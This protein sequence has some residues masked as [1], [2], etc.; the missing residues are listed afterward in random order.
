[1]NFVAVLAALIWDRL[2]PTARALREPPWL[3]AYVRAV[4]RTVG[5]ARDGRLARAAG[6]ALLP[7]LAVL[8]VCALVRGE[9]HGTVYL[10][11][12]TVVLVFALGP[13]D[14]RREVHGYCAAA[15]K[16]DAAAASQLGA[17]L[18]GHDAGQ[19]RGPCLESVAE[20][21]F[22]QANNRLFGVLFWFAIAGPGGALTFRV[23]DLLRR[24]AIL[25]AGRA[26]APAEAQAVADA[27]QRL[28]GYV[29]FLPARLVAVSYGIAGSFD[30]AFSGWR[31]YL[32]NE[33]D[34]FFD[35]NDR[36]LVHAGRGALG[37]AWTAAPDEAARAA[38]ALTLTEAALYVWIVALAVVTLIGWRG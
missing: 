19:R 27:C 34:H 30:E 33:K 12:A 32:A 36:L 5:R 1:M 4:L 3:L 6:G 15:F 10:I 28:H 37:A 18:L 20:A 35:A 38:A 25:R 17:E 21:V 2:V 7:G 14:L 16:G 9:G 22:V 31:S 23:T 11:L 24:E 26:D 13:R 8:L 29:A